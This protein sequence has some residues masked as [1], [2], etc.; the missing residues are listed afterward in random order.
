MTRPVV[1]FF[2][3]GAMVLIGC[4]PDPVAE[5]EA[6]IA[7]LEEKRVAVTDVDKAREEADAAER[8]VAVLLEQ[9]VE[10]EQRELSEAARRDALARAVESEQARLQQSTPDIDALREETAAATRKASQLV[11]EIAAARE[12]ARRVRDQAAALERQLQP[13]DPPWATERRLQVLQDLISQARARYAS[14]PVVRRLAE[15]EGDSIPGGAP[16]LAVEVGRE[17]A[18]RLRQRIT[19]VFAL[20]DPALSAMDAPAPAR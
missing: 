5:V 7:A 9:V 3:L 16:D 13:G 6:E 18:A 17:R 19:D 14:D 15:Q 4:G 12:A 11:V 10:A 1:G 8:A 2:C 20:D